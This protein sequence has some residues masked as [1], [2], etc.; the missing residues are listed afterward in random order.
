M[1]RAERL[2]AE[3]EELRS[4]NRTLQDRL[5][6]RRS[7]KASGQD[8]SNPLDGEDDPPLSTPLKRGQRIDRPGPIR[9]DYSHLP[10]VEDVRDLPVEQRGCPRC[11]AALSPSDTEDSEQIEIE[12]EIVDGRPRLGVQ[13]DG[14]GE[15]GRRCTRRDPVEI[16]RG[17]TLRVPTRRRQAARLSRRPPR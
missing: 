4:E 15:A 5:F 14:P 7:E 6:G 12:I 8:R 13:G 1:L 10:V 2:E 3:S 16:R 11:G 9:R 17:A